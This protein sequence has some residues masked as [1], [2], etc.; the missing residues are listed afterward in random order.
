M[1]CSY[2]NKIKFFKR[3]IKMC[4]KIFFILKAESRWPMKKNGMTFNKLRVLDSIFKILLIITN[5]STSNT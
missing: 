3:T 2:D 4:F 5:Y 1:K